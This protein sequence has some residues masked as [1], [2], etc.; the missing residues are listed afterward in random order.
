V[1]IVYLIV[2]AAQFQYLS[3]RAKLII[4]FLFLSIIPMIILAWQSYSTTKDI[5]EAQLRD[6]IRRSSIS[7]TTAFQD[8]L[9]A[10][11]ASILT[12]ARTPAVVDYMS[13]PQAQRKGSATEAQVLENFD[14]FRK[15]KATYIRSF[16]LFD[17]NGID[18]IDTDALRVGA[19]FSGQEFF[20]TAMKTKTI[21]V[22]GF[23]P[24]TSA[25]HIIYLVAPIISKSG[26]LLG[27]FIVTA[28]AN[29]IQ[30]AT[31]QMLIARQINLPATEYAYLVDGTDYFLLAHTSRID[32]L[33][34][35][36]LAADD[37]RLARLIN[38]TG[39]NQDSL[40]AM[41][42]PQPEL[43]KA[44][45]NFEDTLEFQVPSYSGDLTQS[46][47]TRLSNSNWIVVTSQP[48]STISDIIQNQTR[49][50]VILGVIIALLTALIAIIASNFFTSPIVHLTRVAENISS[51]IFTQKAEV[52]LDDEIGVL[53]RTFNTMTDQIQGL[54]T[55]LENRVE[56]RTF[57]LAQRT[58]DLEQATLHSEKRA[59]QLETIAEI[60]R[61]ISTEKD[62][63]R[64]LP[65]ITQT[66]SES[67]GFYHVG[68]FLLDEN[69]KFA[70]L[71]AA[72]SPGGQI[73]LRRQHKLEVGQIGIV[74]NVTLS[75]KPRVAL[76]TGED[77]AFLNNPD[78]PDTRS[79]M[80]VPLT[81]RGEIIGALDV[82]STSANAFTDE[83]VSIISLLA[84]QLA[85]AIDN[86][87]L[88]EGAQSSLAESRALFTEYIANAWEK[89]SNTA[90][91]GY[92][93]NP[94]GGKVIT[95]NM[96]DDTFSA[97]QN[98][99][100]LAIP[101]QV[102]DQVIGILNV[103][104]KNDEKTWNDDEVNIVQAIA[105][106]LGLAL[107]NARL[108]EETSTRASRERLVSDITTKIRGTNDPQ[109]MV[110]T[111][112]EELQRALG[113]TRIEIVP[114]K[115][116]PPPDK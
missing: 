92:Q 81:A 15:S 114:Q 67:F 6:E 17:K 29:I 110:K 26:E 8:F 54:I 107:D 48:V 61:F 33:Y 50:N 88:L 68:V 36:F 21:Y 18:V 96:A 62:Q 57:D 79:E 64:L 14:S 31:Q 28:N 71:R 66:V 75:G 27:A 41:A 91:R 43:V 105:E 74:G 45:G 94:T 85:I 63:E 37:P 30:S 20:T 80:A 4:G 109:E 3:L 25:D 95:G 98:A 7:T 76:D 19:D 2:L 102:R 59:R 113:V 103:S 22:S 53:A 34:R 65:L 9:D 13:L 60:S 42:L 72:N 97:G 77:A 5:I 47:A 104:A 35:T 89:K 82:Q 40:R 44:L 111:A 51:G 87:R 86:V 78:L 116:A 38:Q 83:D 52:R 1:G 70:L 46:V 39:I 69:K 115:I 99:N 11:L 12:E 16:A 56:Q 93:H 49:Q 108:F 106:R 32:L 100:S 101:I 90:V 58:S 24:L 23:T 84:D 112:I 55:N 73:M 10:Q